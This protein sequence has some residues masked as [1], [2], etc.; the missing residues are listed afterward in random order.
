LTAW[1]LFG[2]YGVYYALAEGVQ[3]ALVADLVPAG[4]RG[5]AMGT[6]NFSVGL[7]A[8]PASIIGG[9]LWD[10]IGPPATFF[11]GATMALLASLLLIG[12]SWKQ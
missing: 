10:R 5:T 7:A 4:L 2:L 8:L 3:R 6:F 12:F 9:F 1:F 11:Y